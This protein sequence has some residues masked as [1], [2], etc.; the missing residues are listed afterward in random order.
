VLAAFV[1]PYAA[2]RERVKSIVTAGNI[3]FVEIHVK[4][5][6]A[7]CEKRDPKGLYAKAR[8]GI[9]QNFTGI[10]DPYEKPTNPD[11][12]LE[13]DTGSIQVLSD[14][15]IQYLDFHGKIENN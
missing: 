1:S 10:S 11:V 6:L 5:S 9:I 4:A 8:A 3:P 12:V 14:Q 7:T 15:V 2:H 13:A